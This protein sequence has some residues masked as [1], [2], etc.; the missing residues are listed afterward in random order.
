MNSTS[1]YTHSAQTFQHTYLV[2]LTTHARTHADTHTHTHT[3]MLQKLAHDIKSVA[4]TSKLAS[5]ICTSPDRAIKTC[6]AIA[7]SYILSSVYTSVGSLSSAAN[8]IDLG[9]DFPGAE[10]AMAE[11]LQVRAYICVNIYIY[12]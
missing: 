10:A 8:G 4:L 9:A 5:R 12:I 1:K 2:T 11:L 6:A 3:H 7:L